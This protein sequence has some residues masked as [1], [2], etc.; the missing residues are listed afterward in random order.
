MYIFIFTIAQSTYLQ[1]PVS[2]Q[3]SQ[4][5]SGLVCDHGLAIN[6]GSQHLV[7]IRQPE[8]GAEVV[9]RFAREA[10]VTIVMTEISEISKDIQR[11]SE[12][13][14]GFSDKDIPFLSIKIEAR[15][16]LLSDIPIENQLPLR[17]PMTF[18]ASQNI[19]GNS[20]SFFYINSS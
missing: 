20:Q 1:S 11:M 6:Q 5:L 19:T 2:H 13:I 7:V 14:V 16:W 18:Q 3:I 4:K 10:L 17:T 9:L 15:L 8:H 12:D